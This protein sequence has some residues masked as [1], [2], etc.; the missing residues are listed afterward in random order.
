MG[1]MNVAK[2]RRMFLKLSRIWSKR[3]KQSHQENFGLPFLVLPA[4]EIKNSLPMAQVFALEPDSTKIDIQKYCQHRTRELAKFDFGDNILND[5]IE[6]ICIR[7][8]G[9]PGI[10][11]CTSKKS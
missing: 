3:P 4:P 10:Y 7:A 8:D 1:L 11:T 9:K 6:R 5:V 2:G